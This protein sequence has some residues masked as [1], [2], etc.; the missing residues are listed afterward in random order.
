VI[1]VKLGGS[2]A[3]GDHLGRWLD[4]LAAGAGR[5]VVVTGGGVF[6]DG[7]RAEQRRHGFGDGAAHHMALL[8]MEQF[9][10]LVADRLR[11]TARLCRSLGEMRETLAERRLPIWL[12]TTLALAD[13]AMAQSWSVTSDSLAAWLA[14]RLGAKRL[15]LI[16]SVPAP[17]PLDAASLA[18]G[19]YVDAAFPDYLAAAPG[20]ALDWV[21]PGEEGRLARLLQS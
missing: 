1:V 9:A 11:A 12:P 13:A 3:E 19:G 5:A 8:A 6:A 10:V 7:V 17:L 18:S 21:G 2:I 14:R 4:A 15:V 20:L 16:K